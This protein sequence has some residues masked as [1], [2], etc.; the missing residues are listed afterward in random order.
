M[1]GN[2]MKT[3]LTVLVAAGALALGACETPPTKEQVGAVS[4]AVIGGVVGSTIGGGS[5]RTVA[6]VAGTIA[7]AVIGGK[8][9]QKMDEADRIKAG[10]ALESVPTGQHSTWKNPDSGTV[11]TV[12]PTKTYETSGT[13]CRDFTVDATV[14]GKPEKV[15][16]T[17]CRQADGNWKTKG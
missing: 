8:I 6:I 13:P 14:D 4:G 9:G 16:G 2:Q 5:G 7:G 17:A 1:K 15:N 3:R 10:Q 12:T 11:Y